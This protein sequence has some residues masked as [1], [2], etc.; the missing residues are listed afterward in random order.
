MDIAQLVHSVNGQH[1]FGNVE[2]GDVFGEDFVL[3]QHGHEITARQE[4]HEHVQ[5][6]RI[7]ERRVQLDHPRAVGVCEDITLRTHVRKLILL[8][9]LRLDQRLHG[10]HLAITALL[11]QLHLAERT[12]A[13]DLDGSVVLGLLFGAE[14]AKILTLLASSC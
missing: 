14:E 4:L 2:T 9:H 12:L 11:D 3:D 7:L 8:E 5:E 10:I 6:V 13:D 1:N